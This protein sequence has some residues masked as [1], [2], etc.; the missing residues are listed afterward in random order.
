M[1]SKHAQLV[2]N[3][4]DTI[5]ILNFTFYYKIPA[6]IT[7]KEFLV[8]AEKA[9]LFPSRY[10]FVYVGSLEMLDH[11]RGSRNKKATEKKQGDYVCRWPP[12]T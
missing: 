8:P 12:E 1:K 7:S 9:C 3:Y 4:M 2:F 5:I 6:A 10:A 11:C